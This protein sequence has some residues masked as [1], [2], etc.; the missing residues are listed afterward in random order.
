MST[1]LIIALVALG[2]LVVGVLGYF[3]LKG[4]KATS[5][6][7]TGSLSSDAKD[8]GSDAWNDLKSLVGF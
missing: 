5:G 7:G 2:V 8:F 1:G 3:A 4:E 6:Q